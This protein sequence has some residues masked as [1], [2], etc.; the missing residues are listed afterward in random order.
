MTRI[1][2]ADTTFVRPDDVADGAIVTVF[3][4]PPEVAGQRLDVFMQ[5]QLRRTSRTRTQYII[6]LS[7]YDDRGKRLRSND[8]VYAG[9][10]VLLWRAPWDE[11]PVPTDLPVLYEDD[12]LLAVDKPPMLPVHPTARYYR[13]TVINLLKD[14]RPGEFLSLAHRIDRETSGVLLVAKTPES[15]RAIKR[16]LEERSRVEKTYLALTWGVPGDGEAAR[17]RCEV[18]LE[19]DDTSSFKVKMRVGRTPSALY[20]ST[21][22]TVEDTLEL[23][24]GRRYARIRCDLETGRQHQIRVHLASYGTP[25]VGDKLYGPD[26]TAFARAA[27]SE[28]TDE[29]RE[30]LEIP[31][32]A[33]HATRMALPHPVTGERL[34]IE[35][36]LPADLASFWD[37][38]AAGLT[39]P[40]TESS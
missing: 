34:I 36:K 33:L 11:T 18:P 8:R 32:H 2:A 23:G 16:M 27:D 12:A 24:D 1:R 9:Q 7:A 30:L 5:S 6:R 17:F 28:L 29:D 38:L 25:I 4:V 13:N 20:A 22:F 14:A 10:Q 3:R 21:W 37:T 35:S 26:E 19:L 15:E 40:R 39:S 31:R